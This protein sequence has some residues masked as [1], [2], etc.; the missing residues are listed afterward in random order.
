MV[1][2]ETDIR[3]VIVDGL[4]ASGLAY[5]LTDAGPEPEL[6]IVDYAN[7]SDRET[8]ITT[9]EIFCSQ[10]VEVR[11]LNVD[12]RKSRTDAGYF[13]REHFPEAADKILQHFR[14]VRKCAGAYFTLNPPDPKL[15]ARYHNRIEQSAT[16]TTS[17]KDI[18][19]RRWILIDC[20][21]ERP[22]GISS[23]Q[24]EFDSSLQTANDIVDSLLSHGLPEPIVAISG[25]GAHIHLPVDL[26]NDEATAA[27][28]KKFLEVL[29][30]G[31]SNEIVHVD[32]SVFNAAR[33]GRIYGTFAGKGDSTADRPHRRARLLKVPDYLQYGWSPSEAATAPQIQRVIERLTKELPPEQSA[34]VSVS[35]PATLPGSSSNRQQTRDLRNFLRD[36]GVDFVEGEPDSR[37]S[38]KLFVTCPFNENHNGKDAFACIVRSSGSWGYHCSHSSCAGNRWHEFKAAI[39]ADSQTMSQ[40]ADETPKKPVSQRVSSAVQTT[41][42]IKPMESEAFPTDCL[43]GRLSSFVQSVSAAV[44]C[45]D[46]FS[47]LPA[48]A[49]VSTAI[50]NSRRVSTKPGNYQPLIVWPVIIGLSG[51]QKSEPFDMATAPLHD[52]EVQ[53]DEQYRKDIAKHKAAVEH[54]KLDLKE[55]RQAGLGDPPQEPEEPVARRILVNDVTSE[56]LIK[57]HSGNPRGILVCNEELSGWFG[58]FERYCGKGAVSGEQA[59]F[60]EFY[61]GKRVTSDRA[62]VNTRIV[63]RSFVNVTG[64]IQPAIIQ[65]ALTAES[66]SNGLAAR[67]W[68]SYPPAVPIRWREEYVTQ[69]VR[70]DYAQLVND[71]LSLSGE[72]DASGNE[73]PALLELSPEARR[74]FA[75]FMNTTGEQTF[76]MFGD[77]RAAFAKFIGRAARIAG[78]IHCCRHAEGEIRDPWT[79]DVD[80]MK[81]AIR[82]CEWSKDETLRV[83]SLLKEDGLTHSLRLLAAWIQQHG[84]TVTARDL[85][86]CK[87]DIGDSEH[88]EELLRSLAA[89]GFGSYEIQATGPAG[90][91]PTAKFTLKNSSHEV[92]DETSQNP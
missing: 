7:L 65:T 66:R 48:L 52:I 45:S 42:K 39:G 67:L 60:L 69:R 54:Y 34:K 44:G 80:S 81:A 41:T 32:R 27:L 70:N 76:V 12:G 31:H 36:H 77:A 30:A 1:H 16:V 23:S 8:I 35:V 13:D 59:K 68:L 72:T 37:Y 40:F 17:D 50:G 58:S 62:S 43:P 19:K 5:T 46:A 92:A 18:L 61:D 49:V 15:L 22:S 84:G 11:F 47:A 78:I 14:S 2:R 51:S 86:R 9:F 79:I 4:E 56:G 85:A 25:N 3:K 6:P 87:R 55:W 82:L 20:D 21:P 10:V 57:L 29:D 83:Y 91:R 71:L 75:E 26:P 89:A 64:T 28:V 74:L 63:Q 33:V 88:A 53:Y 90:G 73:K 24:S 38:A